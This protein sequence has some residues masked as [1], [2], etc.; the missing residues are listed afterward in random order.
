[1]L[2][3]FVKD[4]TGQCLIGST[5][6]RTHTECELYYLSL[7]NIIMCIYCTAH[8][9]I[10]IGSLYKEPPVLTGLQCNT[11]T[12]PVDLLVWSCSY[13]LLNAIFPRK[14]M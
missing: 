8:L 5:K 1:M 14:H 7:K 6:R 2:V 12:A 3:K 11:I 10:I 4:V 9:K 13:F